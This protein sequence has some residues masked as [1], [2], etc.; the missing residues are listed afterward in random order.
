MP[1]IRNLLLITVIV[2]VF[3]NKSYA[4]LS[5]YELAQAGVDTYVTMDGEYVTYDSPCVDEN[6][7]SNEYSF[8]LSADRFPATDSELYDIYGYEYGDPN[9]QEAHY[10]NV[11][12]L[13]NAPETCEFY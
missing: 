7:L 10:V 13:F 8:F 12:C 2:S 9:A 11:R 3:L 6:C 4:Q 5:I 1:I